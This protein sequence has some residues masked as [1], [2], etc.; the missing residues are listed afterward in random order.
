MASSHGS[1]GPALSR[2]LSGSL[3]RAGRLWRATLGASLALLCALEAP[4]WSQEPLAPAVPVAP[5]APTA[6]V[7]PVS[8]AAPAV[9]APVAPAAPSEAVSIQAGAVQCVLGDHADFDEAD[10]R[11]SLDVVCNELAQRGAAGSPYEVRFGKLG[12]KILV[13]VVERRTQEQRRAVAQNMEEILV[14]A[15]RLAEAI[16]RKAAVKDGETVDNVLAQNAKPVVSKPLQAGAELGLTGMTAMGTDMSASGGVYLGLHFRRERWALVGHGRAG[17]IGSAEGKLG[18]AQLDVGGRYFL[19]D[20]DVAPF[21]GLGVGVGYFNV[22]RPARLSLGD[23]SGSGF[24]ASAELGV[25]ILRTSHVGANLSL[26]ADAP[27]FTL[28][29]ASSGGYYSSSSSAPREPAV[30]SRYVVPISLNVALA[31]Q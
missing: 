24:E 22:D 5:A 6:P 10:V 21:V 25:G 18:Y 19:T 1:S 13:V 30:E 15:P 14:V 9:P 2:S 27:F 26:R 8:P 11:T 31:F 16:V 29:S 23:L 17:G 4:A 20:G 28:K 3:P 7:A 12:G